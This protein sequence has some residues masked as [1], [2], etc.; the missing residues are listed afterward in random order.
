MMSF[1]LAMRKQCQQQQ[2]QACISL[3]FDRALLNM[4]THRPIER[5]CSNARD[6]AAHRNA[7]RSY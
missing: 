7:W 5:G 2:K 3:R 1:R 4:D 6:C